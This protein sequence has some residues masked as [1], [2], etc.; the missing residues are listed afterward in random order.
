MIIL[1]FPINIF[2]TNIL[3]SDNLWF[4]RLT[5]RDECEQH[6]DIWSRQQKP[7]TLNSFLLNGGDENWA[8]GSTTKALRKRRIPD[9]KLGLICLC[10]SCLVK[11]VSLTAPCEV[12]LEREMLPWVFSLDMKI[13][14]TISLMGHMS[15]RV[16]FHLI[17]RH[18]A[19]TGVTIGLWRGWNDCCLRYQVTQTHSEA[20]QEL[21]D[22][23]KTMDFGI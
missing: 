3:D 11:G 4:W 12:S 7:W 6:Q 16:S 8:R 22:F 10:W 20:R 19:R 13:F 15:H 14:E 21:I 23:N 5:I 18:Y 9:W 1:R 2:N 17:I